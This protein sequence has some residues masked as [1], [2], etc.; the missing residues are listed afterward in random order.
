MPTPWDLA[1]KRFRADLAAAVDT[2]EVRALHQLRPWRHALLALR[3]VLLLAGAVAAIL[4]AGGRWYVV[5]PASVL[6]GFVVFG[7]T[8][9][10]HEAIHGL[11][12]GARTNRTER[13]LA[14]LY[15]VPSGLSAAQ[16][17]RWHL[18][19]HDN[20]GTDDRDPK[21][22]W[23]TPKVVKRRVKFLYLTPALFP[24]YFRAAR[25]A[26]T[27]YEPALKRRIARERATA[28]L[29][30]L[31]VLG[32]LVAGLGV[33]PALWLHAVP[34]FLVFP[35]AFTV[36]RL[37][38][39]YDVDPGD[40]ARWG[41]LMARSPLT[42]DVL[43]LWSNYHLEHHYFPR[44]PCYHLPRLRRALEPFFRARGVPVRTFAGLLVDWFVHNR[45]PH[46]RWSP[47]P[48][49]ATAP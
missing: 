25:H 12:T 17:T 29:F 32:G 40:P 49:A 44:V 9:L 3:Q 23:L 16:F 31:G 8:V 42:W 36:N 4:L 39:H 2:A 41:T 22:A 45:A 33:L 34:V 6:I 11:V 38:Q 14:Q 46:T 10:L 47:A 13:V 1:A 20:L 19:H 7:F 37:G 18:D 28:T 24:I 21:R 26:A 48:T 27:D 43:Y 15:A 35:V 30:H 5:A